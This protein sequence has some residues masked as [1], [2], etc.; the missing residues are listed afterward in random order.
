VRSRLA[1][2]EESLRM[3]RVRLQVMHLQVAMA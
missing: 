2:L 3:Q 1:D